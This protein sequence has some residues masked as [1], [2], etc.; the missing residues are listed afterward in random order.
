LFYQRHPSSQA[1]FRRLSN[2]PRGHDRRPRMVNSSFAWHALIEGLH[3][4]RAR[5]APQIVALSKRPRWKQ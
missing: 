5:Q 4:R 2:R 1:A 3:R